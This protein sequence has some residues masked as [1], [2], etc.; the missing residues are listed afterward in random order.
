[1]TGNLLH[2]QKAAMNQVGLL[3]PRDLQQM[4]RQS[5]DVFFQEL[6]EDLKLIAEEVKP[7]D[8]VDRN[9]SARDR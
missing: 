9:R 2:Y 5:P 8:F 3:E 7:A 1:M 6:G 4:I